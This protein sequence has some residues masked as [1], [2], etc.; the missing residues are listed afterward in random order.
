MRGEYHGWV[1]GRCCADH[2][3]DHRQQLSHAGD[4]R[5]LLRLADGEQPQI[6]GADHYVT[7]R[8]HQGAHV[9]HPANTGATTRDEAP[10]AYGAR[11]AT[12]RRDADAF[13]DL[14]PRE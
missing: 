12:A 13:R 1:P 7:P 2:H 10:A 5:E 11:I 6:E 3:V 8:R 4:E 9:E 14:P